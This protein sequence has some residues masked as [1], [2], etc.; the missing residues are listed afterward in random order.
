M[1]API[2]NAGTRDTGVDYPGTAGLKTVENPTAS[3]ITRASL[4]QL[5][6]TPARK[7]LPTANIDTSGTSGLTTGD[8][9]KRGQPNAWV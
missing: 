2:G 7:S 1:A 6:A 3:P 5:L 4:E 8:D 9:V